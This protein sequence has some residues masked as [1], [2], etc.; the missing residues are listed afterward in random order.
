[1][2]TKRDEIDLF[3][4]MKYCTISK[5]FFYA[6]LLSNERLHNK[7]NNFKALTHYFGPTQAPNFQPAVVLVSRQLRS[8][9]LQTGRQGK[10]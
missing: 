5:D 4:L 10:L 3:I 7:I 2:V 6:D 9:S 8:P 1:M